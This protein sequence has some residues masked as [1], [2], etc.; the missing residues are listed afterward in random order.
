M[1]LPC[2]LFNPNHSTI[3]I[4]PL[5]FSIYLCFSSFFFLV[6]SLVSQIK[7]K[8]EKQRRGESVFGMAC[9]YTMKLKDG[10]THDVNMSNDVTIVGLWCNRCWWASLMM[11]NDQGIQGLQTKFLAMPL[12]F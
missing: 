4:Y 5:S 10:V 8:V 3:Y 7:T 1:C 11:V 9:N 6:S 2:F 12:R